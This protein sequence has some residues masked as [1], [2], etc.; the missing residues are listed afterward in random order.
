MTSFI[1]IESR[2]ILPEAQ[3]VRVARLRAAHDALGVLLA[4]LPAA[5]NLMRDC[6]SGHPRASLGGRGGEPVAWCWD[7]ERT[8][9]ECDG[10]GLTCAG[11]LLAGPADPT[12][13]A[14]VTGDRAARDIRDVERRADKIAGLVH[15]LGQV[16]AAYPVQPAE[17]EGVRPT[18][19]EEHCRLCWESSEPRDRVVKL[20]EVRPNGKPFYKGLCRRCGRW[21]G[22]LGGDPPAWFVRRYLNGGETITPAV[23]HKARQ[24]VK[25][26]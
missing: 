18:P 20:I 24:A 23:E 7:H 9:N 3:A 2:R 17:I 25:R 8:V 13:G 22:L 19:G 16:L 26:R 21:R 14:A 5:L 4:E 10:R 12:G 15:E 11:E 6:Q 1:S